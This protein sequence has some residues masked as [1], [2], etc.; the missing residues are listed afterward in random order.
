MKVTRV[1][2]RQT[3]NSAFADD[4]ENER[5]KCKIIHWKWKGLENFGT[6]GTISLRK[7][8]PSRRI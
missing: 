1:D 5:N 8:E 3:R 6:N 2:I 4:I 7:R